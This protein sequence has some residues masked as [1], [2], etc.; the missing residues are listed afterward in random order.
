MRVPSKC[1]WRRGGRLTRKAQHHAPKWTQAPAAPN[2]EAS[3]IRWDPLWYPVLRAQMIGGGGPG[4][5]I[6]G[7]KGT[8]PSVHVESAIRLGFRADRT[9]TLPQLG[10]MLGLGDCSGT[11]KASLSRNIVRVHGALEGDAN[12][13]TCDVRPQTAD[14]ARS[15]P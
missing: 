6:G 3:G 9:T 10:G 13:A 1:R 8:R 11:S 7:G 5:R 4:R 14:P 12:E 2:G 15:K